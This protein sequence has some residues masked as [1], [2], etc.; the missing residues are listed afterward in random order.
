MSY[1]PTYPQHHHHNANRR[2]VY[3]SWQPP[4]MATMQTWIRNIGAE[5]ENPLLQVGRLVGWSAVLL[6]YWLVVD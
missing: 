5:N 2:R 4:T 6:A 3:T 1:F